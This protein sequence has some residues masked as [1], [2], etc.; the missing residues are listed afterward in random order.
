MD[1]TTLEIAKLPSEK[2]G[3]IHFPTRSATLTV[4]RQVAGKHE[5]P[6]GLT[7]VSIFVRTPCCC[8]KS[9]RRRVLSTTIDQ[10]LVIIKVVESKKVPEHLFGLVRGDWPKSQL[11]A[12]SFSRREVSNRRP[13]RSKVDLQPELED[14]EG[15]ILLRI[16]L[17]QGRLG[18]AA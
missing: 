17:I 1:W 11:K 5:R 15:T 3:M 16:D 4:E 2:V 6:P 10:E 12:K 14:P 8:R 18:Q 13:K 9:D 7:K